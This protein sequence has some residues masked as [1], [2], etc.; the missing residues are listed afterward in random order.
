MTTMTSVFVQ[1]CLPSKVARPPS[2]PLW[3]HE[4]KH[5]GYRLMVRRDGAR[6]PPLHAQ[7]LMTWWTASRDGAGDGAVV[8]VDERVT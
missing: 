5:D 6:N 1:P 4:I 2:G 7:R 3:V 8:H